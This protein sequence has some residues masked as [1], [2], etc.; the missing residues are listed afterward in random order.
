MQ[1][2]RSPP[3]CRALARKSKKK[4]VSDLAQLLIKA[5]VQPDKTDTVGQ[6]PLARAALYQ[7][8]P[9]VKLLSQRGN[10]NL[11]DDHGDTPLL[12]AVNPLDRSQPDLEIIQELLQSGANPDWENSVKQTA[13]DVTRNNE[14]KTTLQRYS[15]LRKFSKNKNPLHALRSRQIGI[16]R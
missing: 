4:V 12:H 10:I 11:P 6:T 13:S 3:T 16:R 7:N 8:L 14:I 5:G 9:I 15:D 1:P 2:K